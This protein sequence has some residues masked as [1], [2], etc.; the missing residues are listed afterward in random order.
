MY[1]GAE[2]CTLY[3]VMYIW[4][5]EN[6]Y[7]FGRPLTIDTYV[8]VCTLY[9]LYYNGAACFSTPPLSKLLLY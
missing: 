7:H 3:S 2:G 5:N 4:N 9:T 1:I 8:L 6:Q